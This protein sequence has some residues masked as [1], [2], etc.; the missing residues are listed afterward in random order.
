[1]AIPRPRNGAVLRYAY[2]WKV[3]QDAGRTEARKERPAAVILT[4]RAPESGLE[5]VYVLPITHGPPEQAQ[6]A[7]EIPPAEMARLGLDEERSWIVCD[8]ANRFLWPGYDLRPIPGSR[9]PRWEYGMLSRGTY[10][11]A[12]DLF[13]KCRKEMRAKVAQRD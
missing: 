13:L 4:H 3:E 9:P 11:R 1:M 8:E 7:V 2:L 12:K 10:E 5:T 6:W